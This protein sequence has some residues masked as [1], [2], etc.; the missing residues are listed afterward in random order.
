MAEGRSEQLEPNVSR[1]AKLVLTI[2]AGYVA[3]GIL[4]LRVAGMGWFDAINHA[5]ATLSTGGISTRAESIGYWDSP[6]IEAVTIVLM[7]LGNLN[8]L[9][10]YNLLQSKFLAVIRNG[11]IQLQ[12][13]LLPVSALILFVG[14]TTGLY[15][16]QE[17]AVRVAIFETISAMTTTGYST[18]SYSNWQGLGLLII[19]VLMLIGGG[20]GSSSGGVK[21]YRIYVL[22]R[23]LLWEIRRLLLPQSV[24]TE[25]DI[26]QGEYR[27]FLSD[28]QIRQVGLF[29]F[30]YLI[31]YVIGSGAIAA[32]G[33]SLPASLFEFASSLS[34]VGLSVG[35][36]TAD[37]PTGLL[38]V[39]TVGMFLGRLEFFTVFVGVI[40]FL[41][42]V[43]TILSVPLHKT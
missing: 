23:A 24:V 11:E 39:E 33:Y 27:E 7:I 29:V 12:L 43:R 17:K 2:Y 22:C 18:V 26:W 3:I 16:T 15:P 34:A 10:T 38:W 21:Q 36:T 20:T 6:T 32:Y 1:S 9:S 25:P 30:L 40:K 4:A 19:I 8:F 31:I 41:T 35:V 28:R 13:L 42:D 5:F 37:A 14:V